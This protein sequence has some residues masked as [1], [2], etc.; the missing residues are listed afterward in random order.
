[1]GCSMSQT[2][3]ETFQKRII[4]SIATSN[5]LN[6]ATDEAGVEIEIEP[7]EAGI[8]GESLVVIAAKEANRK[9]A[10]VSRKRPTEIQKLDFGDIETNRRYLSSMDFYRK[11]FSYNHPDAQF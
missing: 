6:V 4:E 3:R 1:M 2:N 11:M 8:S 10:Y 7:E 9:R 5:M